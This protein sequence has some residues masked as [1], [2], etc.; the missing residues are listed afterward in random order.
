[1]A[2]LFLFQNIM[3]DI[4]SLALGQNVVVTQIGVVVTNEYWNV[5]TTSCFNLSIPEQLFKGRRIN[6]ST[7]NWW[8]R[9]NPDV[10]DKM[11]S[12][13][14][15]VNQALNNI[16]Y[17]I[18]GEFNLEVHELNDYTGALWWANSNCF[19]LFNFNSLLKQFSYY[20]DPWK[21]FQIDQY[22]MRDFKSIRDYIK[23][24]HNIDLYENSTVTHNALEDALQQVDYMQKA[25]NPQNWEV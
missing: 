14:L 23:S 12:S 6:E 25:T 15:P 13:P 3:I 10:I 9:Q 22:Y 5:K 8:R 1:M 4:E 20:D 16:L 7:L 19:D 21:D 11:I 18:A 17:T 24:Y 2:D